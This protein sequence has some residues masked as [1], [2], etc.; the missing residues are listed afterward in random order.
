MTRRFS[1]M[2]VYM[3]IVCI[4]AVVL[5]HPAAVDAYTLSF[6]DIPSGNDLRHYYGAQYGAVFTVDWSVVSVDG[7]DWKR[8]HGGTNVAMW[9]G[10]ANNGAGLRF[11]QTDED[12][13]AYR[14]NISS[15]GGFF[16]TETDSVVAM[17][18]YDRT[19]WIPI[20]STIIGA[21]GQSWNN[22]YAAISSDAG[23]I[24]WVMFEGISSP[25]AR[26]QFC[27]DDVTITPVPEP[28]SLSALALGLA[29]LAIGMRRKR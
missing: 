23:D 26:Y 10:P 22:R 16:S 11:G 27:M 1:V 2:S 4:L 14:Y 13:P 15:I 18:G 28:S 25:D 12:N 24:G 17:V 29:P 5:Y 3:R 19:T 20:V 8:S 7:S 6:D 21:P 9:G